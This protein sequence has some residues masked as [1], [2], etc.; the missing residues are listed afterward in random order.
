MSLMHESVKGPAMKWALA[1]FSTRYDISSAFSLWLPA[2]EIRVVT[3]D[4]DWI[5]FCLERSSR[6]LMSGVSTEE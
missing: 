4:F 2:F 1:D 3:S 6:L 5:I